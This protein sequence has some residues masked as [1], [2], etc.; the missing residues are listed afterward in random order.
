M[1]NVFNEMLSTRDFYDNFGGPGTSRK[2]NIK[3]E[4]NKL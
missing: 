1:K 4:S 2:G 3:I